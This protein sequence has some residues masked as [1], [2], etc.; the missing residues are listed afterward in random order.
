MR[1]LMSALPSL[2]HIHPCLEV[3]RALQDA[4]HEVRIATTPVMTSHVTTGG[5][6]PVPMGTD[7]PWQGVPLT[8]AIQDLTRKW[9]MDSFA[10]WA[11]ELCRYAEEWV[12]DVMIHDWSQFAGVAAAERLK[13]PSA[14]LGIAVRPPLEHIVKSRCWPGLDFEGINRDPRR[15][16][17]DLL[18]NLYPPSFA[19]PGDSRLSGEHYVRPAFYDGGKEGAPPEWLGKLAGASL[20]YASMGTFYAQV[21]GVFQAIIEAAG[22][23]DA[24]FIVTLGRASRPGEFGPL[25]ANVRVERYVPQS[26]VLPHCSAVICQGGFNLMLPALAQG[27]PTACMPVTWGALEGYGGAER[28]AQLGA[29]Q[30]YPI[31][32]EMEDGRSDAVHVD[33]ERIRT[34]MVSLLEDPSYSQ[35]AR[36]IGEEIRSLPGIPQAVEMIEALV[37]GHHEGANVERNE[38]EI[39]VE[40][41][42]GY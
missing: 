21:P 27:V 19:I 42:A 3:G 30:I 5:I 39:L 2:G 23:V 18:L 14:V 17:G 29:G 1:A 10:Q 25:P 28:C 35:A 15:A 36:R 4:G 22:Q 12:P 8:P 37:A 31:G 26:Q 16:F 11:D 20:V 40:D 24:Q 9:L 13:L 41:T 6:T 34:M 38:D 33:P 7:N 32:Q